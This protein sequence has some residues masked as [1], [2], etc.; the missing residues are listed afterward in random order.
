MQTIVDLQDE[1]SV[2][3][4]T[5][6]SGNVNFEKLNINKLY[7][8]KRVINFKLIY[9]IHLLLLINVT[10]RMLLKITYV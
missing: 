1:L 7:K 9:L 10:Y 2:N 6:G 5:I 8:C 3:V 4:I